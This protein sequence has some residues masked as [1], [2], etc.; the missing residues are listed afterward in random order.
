MYDLEAE[1][2]EE[3]SFVSGDS[4]EIVDDTSADGWWKARIRGRTGLT[5]STFVR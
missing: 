1:T 2:N 4:L 3:L 5:P